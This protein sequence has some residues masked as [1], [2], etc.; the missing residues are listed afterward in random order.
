MATLRVQERISTASIST[1][2]SREKLVLEETTHDKPTSKKK[3]GLKK[4]K[5]PAYV[6]ISR[7]IV[8]NKYFI[9]FTT[10]L[11]IYAL[12]GDDFRLWL[13]PVAADEYFDYCVWS[14]IIVFTIEVILSCLGKADY[15]PGFFFFLDVI[16]TVT[17]V[18]DLSYVSDE[19]SKAEKM[20]V[21]V[22]PPMV[23]ARRMDSN[24]EGP[25]E[26]A[27]KQAGSCECCG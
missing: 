23:Q 14:C 1:S 4:S 8:D 15:Y 16:S 9:A 25:H 6:A 10:L 17:L 27:R 22:N 2:G 18:L 24:L 26:W 3:E 11:T 7:C 13:T 21:L 12:S 5:T 20:K 19:M